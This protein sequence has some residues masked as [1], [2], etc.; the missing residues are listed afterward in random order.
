[1]EEV[2]PP[3]PGLEN[4]VGTPSPR[5]RPRSPPPPPRPEAPPTGVKRLAF[6]DIPPTKRVLMPP[7]GGCPACDRRG[8][9]G[10]GF[11][12]S[13]A[14][15]RRLFVE[16][17]PA[18]YE[19]ARAGE[20]E[21]FAISTPGPAV[22]MPAPAVDQPA[23]EDISGEAATQIGGSSSS[24]GPDAQTQQL[25]PT[26]QL[27]RGRSPGEDTPV[28]PVT[29][30]ARV[31][32]VSTQ[33]ELQDLH[34]V[35]Q[36]LEAEALEST[37]WTE[38]K[39]EYD[40]DFAQE[41]QQELDRLADSGTYEVI[42]RWQAEREGVNIVKSG[43]VLTEQSGKKKAR[44]VAKEIAYKRS[45]LDSRFFAATPSVMG[46]RLLLLMAAVSGWGCFVT[47][48]ASVFLNA[49]LPSHAKY[50]VELPT[51]QRGDGSWVWRLRKALYGLRGAPRYW[52][53]HLCDFLSGIGFVR[54]LTDSAIFV[55]K[56]WLVILIHVDDLI[57]AGS[58]K[59]RRW[60]EEKLKETFTLKHANWLDKPGDRSIF[61]GKQLVKTEAGFSV[62]VPPGYV[63]K[64]EELAGLSGA[65]PSR[66]PVAKVVALTTDGAEYVGEA[67]H[68][69]YRTLVGMLLWLSFERTDIQFG[70][71]RLTQNISQPVGDDWLAARKLVRYLLGTKEASLVY[72]PSAAKK[73]YLEIWVDAD[74]AGCERTRRS[75]SGGGVWLHGCLVASWSRVQQTVACSSAESEY[76]SMCTGSAEGLFAAAL[77]EE[78]GLEH[79]GVDLNTDASAAKAMAERTSIPTRVKHMQIRFLFLQ[80]LVREKKLRLN[81]VPGERNRSDVMTKAVKAD[82]LERLRPLLGLRLALLAVQAE[83]AGASSADQCARTEASGGVWATILVAG[84]FGIIL[85]G[86]LVAWL[87]ARFRF[88]APPPTA[89]P[90]AMLVVTAKHE[91][92]TQTDRFGKDKSVQGPV[93]YTALRGVQ[94]ARFY[95]LGEFAWGAWP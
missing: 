48:I 12:H 3:P 89:T 6:D 39:A 22:G 52:Q 75:T 27:V 57:A 47:D 92:S 80:Q 13:V 87:V 95:P 69:V 71:K 74:W 21:Q 2:I 17:G 36:S 56:G 55:I 79:A 82:I 32:E 4:V 8:E 24:A 11:R 63:D 23:M 68:A 19:L 76:Y 65:K 58:L 59:A 94:T 41:K 29:A 20:P 81:K 61:V 34:N 18:G 26:Q 15:R 93:T 31:E 5:P 62:S 72:E 77:A 73:V 67:Q 10:H 54:L 46:L 53:E 70:V 86:L 51:E 28:K 84:L 16:T 49:W 14:C 7:L 66:V 1:M 45:S 50:A 30:K 88:G 85:G 90:V 35:D 33:V 60:L 43:F 91:K 40:D 44:F 37:A 64:M 83:E 78:I 9:W 38:E 42:P 25:V